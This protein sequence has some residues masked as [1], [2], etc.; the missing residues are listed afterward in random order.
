MNALGRGGVVI[1]MSSGLVATMGL[2]AQAASNAAGPETAA[3]PAAAPA[4]GAPAGAAFS[5]ASL[6]AA[7]AFQSGAPLTAPA[8]ATVNFETGKFTA[9]PKP[10][11]APVRVAD[12]N[13]SSGSSSSGS[14]SSSS[15]GSGGFAS[16]KGSSVLSVAARY[17]GV[18]YVYGGTTPGGGFDCSGAVRYIYR[19]LGVELPRTANQQM[20]ASTRVSRSNAKVGDLVFVV[21]G[22]RATHVGIYAGNNMMYDAGSSGK[23]FSKR[24]IW[25]SNVLFG[26]V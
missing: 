4:A 24:E 9:V 26:R 23:S 14:S 16:A 22:G 2:P 20:L 3:A 25:T 21:S 1:A 18:P 8:A 7:P 19:Q 10:K 12:D 5:S 13:S 11:P 6:T 17:V 15:Y